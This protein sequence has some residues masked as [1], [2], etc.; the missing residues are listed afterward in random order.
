MLV[1]VP[2]QWRRIIGSSRRAATPNFKKLSDRSFFH[3]N[4]AI[5]GDMPTIYPRFARFP[6]QRRPHRS[7]RCTPPLYWCPSHRQ[8]FS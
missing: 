1:V 5:N 4:A 3:H 7:S 8:S 6:G 2:G